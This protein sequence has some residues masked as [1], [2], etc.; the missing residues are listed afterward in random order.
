MLCHSVFTCRTQ[1]VIAHTWTKLLKIPRL[2]W[3]RE[4]QTIGLGPCEK[5]GI[6]SGR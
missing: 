4:N 5:D 3:R 6:L 2:Y 1:P